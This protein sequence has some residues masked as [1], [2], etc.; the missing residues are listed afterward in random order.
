[1]RV[2]PAPR[3]AATM[4]HTSLQ[5]DMTGFERS[6]WHLVGR[7]SQLL[8]EVRPQATLHARRRSTSALAVSRWC[9]HARGSSHTA[10][11]GH[12]VLFFVI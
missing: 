4:F 12:A 2:S 7:G 6:S 10:T 8:Q 9:S 3:I 11:L 5:L 1:M